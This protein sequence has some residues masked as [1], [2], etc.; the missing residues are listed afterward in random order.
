MR[1]FVT[2]VRAAAATAVAIGGLLATVSAIVPASAAGTVSESPATSTTW[3]TDIPYGQTSPAPAPPNYFTGGTATAPAG[4]TVTA[5]SCAAAVTSTS[6]AS[7]GPGLTIAGVNS[8]G[9][10]AVSAGAIA[11]LSYGSTNTSTTSTAVVGQ[12]AGQAS[13]AGVTDSNGYLVP[14]S[15]TFTFSGHD[16]GIDLRHLGDVHHKRGT[17]RLHDGRWSG[18]RPEH[19]HLRHQLQPIQQPNRRRHRWVRIDGS[20]VV[21]SSTP[22]TGFSC[23]PTTEPTSMTTSA[24]FRP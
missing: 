22:G 2:G 15:Y 11:V 1:R 17:G 12:I 18:L 20:S 24:P 13:V 7:G 14:G 8:A 16:G 3:A 4:I 23:T 9:T 5:K 6:G 19:V 21:S 10:S